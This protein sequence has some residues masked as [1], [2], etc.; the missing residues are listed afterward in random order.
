M[1]TSSRSGIAAF[2]VLYAVACGSSTSQ[3]NSGQTSP[4][5]GDDG[6]VS[7]AEGGLDGSAKAMAP[8]VMTSSGGCSAIGD[9]PRC[10]CIHNLAILP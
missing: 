1:T 10:G 5:A 3:S 8:R 4:D 7:G 2:V 6:R 9:T